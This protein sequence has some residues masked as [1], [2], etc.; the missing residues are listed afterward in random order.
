VAEYKICPSCG[1]KN[2]L[3]ENFCQNVGCSDYLF[4]AETISEPDE[5]EM[6]KEEIT[7]SSKFAQLF[8]SSPSSKPVSSDKKK[9]VKQINVKENVHGDNNAVLNVKNEKEF[10]KKV[11][12]FI[13][14]KDSQLKIEPD[15]TKK[16]IGRGGREGNKIEAYLSNKLYVSRKHLRIW[17]TETGIYVCDIGSTNGTY[18]NEKKLKPNEE[19]TL[20][21]GDVLVLGKPSKE[22]ANIA[23]FNVE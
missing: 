13:I 20:N 8:S 16:L 1:F 6:N 11:P 10:Q 5:K 15:S 9:V 21:V 2:P 22:E 18:I 17:K 19:Y 7:S 23:I 12:K 14:T 4:G 3:S